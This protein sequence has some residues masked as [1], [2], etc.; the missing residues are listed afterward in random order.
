M[1]QLGILVNS[2]G[3]LQ[4][5]VGLTRAARAAGT[6][7]AIFVMD[8]GTRLLTDRAFTALAELEGV[9]L[10]VCE[11]SAA[12]FGVHPERPPGRIRFGSQLNNASMVAASDRVVVL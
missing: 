7:V 11:H 5:I 4:Q 9:N 2:A 1:A 6:P 12:A 8:E 3:H 10:S